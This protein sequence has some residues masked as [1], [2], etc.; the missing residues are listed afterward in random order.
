MLEI[1]IPEH[2]F[3]LCSVSEILPSSLDLSDSR[4]KLFRSCSQYLPLM[5]ASFF[6]EAKRQWPPYGVNLHLKLQI[7]IN[8][9]EM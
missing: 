2:N 9:S 7:A 8:Y 1:H 5:I 6:P 4:P 3:D